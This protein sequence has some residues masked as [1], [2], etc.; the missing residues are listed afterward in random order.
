MTPI[1]FGA[2]LAGTLVVIMLG[3]IAWQHTQ[4]C[5][6]RAHYFYTL[7]KDN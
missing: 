4:A 2:A 5:E 6:N 3:D 1:R 7:C